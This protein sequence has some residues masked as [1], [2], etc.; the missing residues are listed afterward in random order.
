MAAKSDLE[1]YRTNFRAEQESALLNQELAKA[2]SDIH[3]AEL[4]RRMSET[5]QRHAAVWAQHL[6]DAG[7]PEPTYA[8]TF[9]MRA[10][11][12]LAKR[13]GVSSVLPLISTMERDAGRVYEG[14]PEARAAGMPAQE[15][16]HARLFPPYRRL[17][18][19]ASPGHCWRVSR[20]DTAAPGETPCEPQYWGPATG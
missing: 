15:R 2:E 20:A 13:F 18:Q 5:E 17:S 4:Y 12:W 9:R 16:S 10:L 11:I 19:V 3:L 6:R 1:R 8:P 14:Q 7:Q